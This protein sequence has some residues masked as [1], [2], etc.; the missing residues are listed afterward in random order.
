MT[1]SDNRPVTTSSRGPWALA[2]AFLGLV[3][4]LTTGA[5]LIVRRTAQV[6]LE[7]LE[8][9]RELAREARGIA[10]AF[11]TG[12]VTYAFASSATQLNGTSR[13]QVASLRQVELFERKDEAAVFWGQLE[14]PDVV[15]EARAPVEYV[16]YLDLDAPWTFTL[17]GREVRVLAPA[18]AFNAPA[19][20][21]SALEYRVREGSWLRDE[22]AALATLK[23]GLTEL[24]RRRAREH[25]PLVRETARAQAER[26]VETWLRRSFDDAGELRARVTFADEQTARPATLPTPAP[27]R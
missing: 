9:G 12:K 17:E 22:E 16:Y 7:V 10:E 4:I 23:A 6:P 27:A 21:A 5:V 25:L 19:V 8:K 13:L 1:S 11:R 2:A 20:D 15:V 18:P 3:A 14:L 24:T 26:F